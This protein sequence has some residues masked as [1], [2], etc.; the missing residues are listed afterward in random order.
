MPKKKDWF[1]NPRASYKGVKW[2]WILPLALFRGTVWCMV[3]ACDFKDGK[4]FFWNMDNF[5]IYLA[6]RG[7]I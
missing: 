2:Y 4:F 1:Y 7:F 6:R 5:R 3:E